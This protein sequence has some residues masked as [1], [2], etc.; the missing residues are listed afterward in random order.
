MMNDIGWN[1][2]WLVMGLM[3]VCGGLLI[4]YFLHRVSGILNE[5]EKRDDDG[6]TG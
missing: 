5:Q 3:A 6:G 4:G 1:E 2:M